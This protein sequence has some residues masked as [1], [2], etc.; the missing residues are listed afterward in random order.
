MPPE[1]ESSAVVT[2]TPAALDPPAA[3]AF[4]EVKLLCPTPL[5]KPSLTVVA[6]SEDDAWREF[7]QENGI[8]SSEHPR[9]IIRL[10]G[11]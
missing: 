6:A 3:T 4:Y 5:A 10:S 7:C 9:S 11:S 8:S 1:L 2:A